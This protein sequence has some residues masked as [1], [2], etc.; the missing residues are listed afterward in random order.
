MCLTGVLLAVCGAFVVS[1]LLGASSIPKILPFAAAASASD[2][3]STPVI[4]ASPDAVL[5]GQTSTLTYNVT[6]TGGNSPYWCEWLERPP[7]AMGYSVLQGQKQ[8][9]GPLTQSTG[10]L[11][12]GGTWY[13]MLRVTDSSPWPQT[14]NSKPVTVT[15]NW[16]VVPTVILTPPEIDQSQS[17]TVAITVTWLA[18]EGPPYTVALYSGSSANCSSASPLGVSQGGIHGNTAT[19]S[20]SPSS[21]YSYSTFYCAAVSD[22]SSHRV[23]TILGA[24]FTVNPMLLAFFQYNA[25]NIDSNQSITLQAAAKFGTSPYFYQWFSGGCSDNI[26]TGSR[27]TGI[28]VNSTFPT[29]RLTTIK[30]MTI[31]VVN[32]SVKVTDSSTAEPPESV[33]ANAA[34]SVNPAL[35]LSVSAAHS[36]VDLGQ[37]DMLTATVEGGT[38]TKIASGTSSYSYLWFKGEHCNGT[39]LPDTLPTYSASPKSSGKTS[40]SVKVLTFPL[41]PPRRCAKVSQLLSIL[42]WRLISN[43]LS[44]QSIGGRRLPSLPQCAGLEECPPTP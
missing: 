44:T 21:Y 35:E 6:L 18:S 13:F 5:S 1:G 41:G 9:T 15:V 2:P 40:Y 28:S 8:C 29:G 25:P 19:F 39:S 22:G 38:P 27:L 20:I 34:V 36:N 4:G 3:P 31:N 7:G 23:E 10:P 42:P 24:Q 37:T 43:S 33:C 16:L 17:V 26:P 30:P 14:V 32:Y 12:E 11:G